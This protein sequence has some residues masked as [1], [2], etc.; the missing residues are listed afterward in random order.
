MG[1][2]DNMWE[3][4]VATIQAAV[5]EPV[6]AIGGLQPAG[7]WGAFGMTKLSGAAGM[8]RQHEAN[9]AAGALTGR[10]GIHTNH[11]T[12]LA[13]TADKLYAL[14]TKVSGYSG[15]KVRGTLAEWNRADIRVQLVP[16]KLATKVIIDHADGGHY[17]LESTNMTGYNQPLLDALTSPA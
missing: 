8:F 14:D 9:K 10:K 11:Q 3:K 17:E 7:T 12:Y 15:I 1:L 4:Q 13:L 16:G 6:I 2:F 5:P